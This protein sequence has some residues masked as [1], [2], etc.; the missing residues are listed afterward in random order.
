MRANS[1]HGVLGE[2][3]RILFTTRPILLHS[4]NLS[5]HDNRHRYY[6]ESSRIGEVSFISNTQSQITNSLYVSSR[7]IRYYSGSA[8]WQP[9]LVISV[10]ES[11]SRIMDRYI[12]VV[13]DG[14][15]INV[16]SSLL[17]AS[18]NRIC[19][20]LGSSGNPNEPARFINAR[21]SV[22]ALQKTTDGILWGYFLLKK[23]TSGLNVPVP[24]K[25]IGAEGHVFPVSHGFP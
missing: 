18:K 7:F 2:M 14:F 24:A 19:D 10:S 5:N 8:F 20:N 22:S 16:H 15:V 9:L 21:I 3:A 17:I 13:V 6:R 12:V 1:F 23:S 25:S 4:C 11:Y